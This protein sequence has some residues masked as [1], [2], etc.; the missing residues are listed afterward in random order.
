MDTLQIVGLMQWDLGI[1]QIQRIPRIWSGTSTCEDF[2]CFMSPFHYVHNQMICAWQNHF[3]IWGA[4]M[5]SGL[6]HCT[7]QIYSYVKSC[8]W[9]MGVCAY[10]YMKHIWGINLLGSI[11]YSTLFLVQRSTHR[12]SLINLQY[13]YLGNPCLV[14]CSFWSDPGPWVNLKK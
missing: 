1:C 6:L 9:W 8:K 5:S 4:F 3:C 12:C 2:L 11:T 7:S 10:S 14:T 13:K